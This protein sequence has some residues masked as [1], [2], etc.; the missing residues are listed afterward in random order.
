M[1]ELFSI[2]GEHFLDSILVHLLMLGAVFSAIG[3]ALVDHIKHVI[4]AH[5]FKNLWVQRIDSSINE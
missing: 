4:S 1:R 5:Q 3:Y 2:E